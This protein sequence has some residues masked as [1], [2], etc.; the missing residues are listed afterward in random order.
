MSAILSADDLNDFISPGVA[1]IKPIET[2]PS[3]PPPPSQDP[4]SLEHEVILDGQPGSAAANAPPAEISLTDCLACSGCVTSAEAVLVSLQSHTEV[5]HTLDFGPAL[6]IVG[7]DDDGQFR[8]DGLEDESRRLFVASVSPQTRASLAAAAGK[9]TTEKEAGHMLERLL[10]GPDGLASAGKH[11]NGFAWVLD[12]NVAREACLVLGADEVLGAEDAPAGSATKPILT[13]SCPGW[14]CYAEKTHPYVLPHLS[15]VKSPQALMGTLL[16]TTLSKKLGIPPSRIWHLAV[17]PC[18]DKKLE[19]SREELTDSVWAGDGTPGRGVRDVDCVITSKEV[20]MLAESRGFNFFDLARSKPS[21][22][23]APF[24]DARLDKFLF[25]GRGAHRSSQA[26]GTSGGNLYFTLQTVVS[27]HP[28]SRIQVV[29]GRNADVVEFVVASPAGDPIFK[30]ARYYGFRNIQNLVRKLK[31]ARPSRMPGGKAFGAARRPAGKSAGLEYAYVEVMACPGGCTNGGGQIKVDD[32]IVVERRGFENK[33]GPLEQKVFLA[34][35]DEAYFSAEDSDGE[36]GVPQNG[37]GL[38][39]DIVD[40]IS[41]S[42]I[43]D[44]LA[45]WAGITGIDLGRMALTT[46]REVVS[47]VGKD[48]ASDTERVVQLAGKIG[49]GW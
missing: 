35:V 4:S 8:V 28:G 27:K 7:P 21:F 34:E 11:N 33:P 9:G 12:T 46:Y 3:A 1:C 40:G 6:R 32:P 45:H 41:P 39:A 36:D 42:Y 37:G 13:S 26:A 48:K 47:D 14:V 49:G 16:K 44:T 18:F 31:P 43:R 23:R 10:A 5:L 24:P 15:R 22:E 29:R 20:L 17:M 2:L 25:P 38:G 19:A 30:A